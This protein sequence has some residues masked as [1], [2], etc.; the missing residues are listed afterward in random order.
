[1]A[2]GREAQCACTVGAHTEAAKVLLEGTE[3]IVRGTTLK[4]RYARA[5]ITALQLAGAA[6]QFR[7]GAD[8]VSLALGADEATR[9]LNKL[10]TPPPTLAAK[11]G[12]GAERPAAVL[13]PTDDA[14]LAQALQG[15][16]TDVMPQATVLLAVVA[17]AADLERA[18][19]VHAGMPCPGLW[20]V[21]GK[22]RV[23][24]GDTAVRALMHA[25]GYRDHKSCAV[26][27]A[28]TATRYHRGA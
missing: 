20:V 2:V 16:T 4:R 7:S 24:F 9:W 13:G 12:I 6:L 23:A 3:I 22:G 5:S 11:L 14:A 10:Q 8:V 19:A 25:R 21:R 15:A 27:D 18:L 17:A 1:M 26:S 28:L